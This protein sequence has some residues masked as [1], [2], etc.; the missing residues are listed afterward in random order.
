MVRPSKLKMAP[1]AVAGYKTAFGL[2]CLILT[3]FFSMSI[4][5]S[6]LPMREARTFVEFVVGLSQIHM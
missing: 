6:L 2:A 3:L 4:L 5:V 1:H